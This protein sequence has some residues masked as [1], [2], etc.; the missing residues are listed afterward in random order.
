M[1]GM[2]WVGLSFHW[3]DSNHIPFPLPLSSDLFFE[4]VG[5]CGCSTQHRETLL[6][7][8]RKEICEDLL[9]NPCLRTWIG[10]LA[11]GHRPLFTFSTRSE[12]L[13]T[14]ARANSPF[15]SC[16]SF[17]FVYFFFFSR[18]NFHYNFFFMRARLFLHFCRL[19]WLAG[20]ERCPISTA[21]SKYECAFE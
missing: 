19:R 3:V 17:S 4:P 2:S 5:W 16:F 20:S 9:C 11:D 10:C 7:E 8:R 18:N 6:V 1:G 14:R 12:F 21:R 13:C 15:T